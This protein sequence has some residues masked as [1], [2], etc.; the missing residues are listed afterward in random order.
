MAPSYLCT[1]YASQFCYLCNV[2]LLI[3]IFGLY[4]LMLNAF[5]CTDTD[6]FSNNFQTEVVAFSNLDHNH[7]TSD[8]CSPFCTCHCCH[9]HTVDFSSAD[10]KLINTEIYSNL[11]LH[12]DSLGQ[13]PI[14]SL[15]DP[16]RV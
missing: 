12:F 16:P 6:V 8:L 7:N 10:F 5:P 14:L 15:L 11:F 13:E 2:K 4:V 1:P 9:V 3:F